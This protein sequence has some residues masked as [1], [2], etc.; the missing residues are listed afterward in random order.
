[1][2][3]A[4]SA[5]R[6]GLH[7][8]DTS[9]TYPSSS[10]TAPGSS[11]AYTEE[12]PIAAH[13]V[14]FTENARGIPTALYGEPATMGESPPHQS[15][16]RGWGRS[17]SRSRPRL[18]PRPQQVHL[19]KRGIWALVHGATSRLDSPM[20]RRSSSWQEARKAASVG[21]GCEEMAS[22][23]RLRGGG[24][25]VSWPNGEA[26]MAGPARHGDEGLQRLGEVQSE[27]EGAPDGGGGGEG[28]ERLPARG[29]ELRT[30]GGRGS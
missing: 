19:A 9:C 2:A 24:A 10:S 26:V 20:A 12:V 5:L 3:N 16:G 29:G 8:S 11:L 22:T 15:W 27:G 23:R 30:G 14:S 13:L 1:M 7:S 6:Y 18:R 4:S 17:G 21:S 28:R 25:R